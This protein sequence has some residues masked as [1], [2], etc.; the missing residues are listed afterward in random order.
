[1][2]TAPDDF[3]R[4]RGRVDVD[5]LATMRVAAFGVGTVGS[6]VVDELS[7]CGVGSFRLV[8]GDVLEQGNTGRHVLKR[9]YVG[10]NKAEGMAAFLRESHPPPGLDVEYFEGYVDDTMS[11]DHLDALIHDADLVVA[12]TDD[13]QAQ[14][15]VAR[16]ALA[17]DIPAVFP[18][19]YGNGGGEVFVSLG[20]GTPCLLC[21]EAFRTSNDDLRNVTALNVEVLSVIALAVQVALGVLDPNSSFARMFAPQPGDTTPRTLFVYRPFAALQYATVRRRQNCPMCNVG[22]ARGAGRHRT[23]VEAVQDRAEEAAAG[24]ARGIATF[25]GGLV[26]LAFFIAALVTV[27][28][29]VTILFA[30]SLVGTLWLL[31]D[32]SFGEAFEVVRTSRAFQGAFGLDLCLFGGAVA[33]RLTVLAL[34]FALLLGGTLVP[35][36]SRTG[37][38]Q[39]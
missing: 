18:A 11:D 36:F 24:D 16:R 14:R 17:N 34:L 28:A 22:P 30:A 26:M 3:S 8:D 38:S 33:T 5:R 2:A 31:F 21:W 15:R 12:A 1:M 4:F 39:G 20:P 7:A 25:I 10:R 27:N 6:Q 23:T 13:R 19:L 9:G 29:T 35:L 32:P 37:R